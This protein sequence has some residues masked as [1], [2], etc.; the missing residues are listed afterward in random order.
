[1][2]AP[3]ARRHR[4]LS[5]RGRLVAVLLCCL[6]ASCAVVATATTLALRRFLLDR[7]DQQLVT[8]GD[9]YAVSL[10]HPSDAD[11]DDGYFRSV[12]GQPAGTLGARIVD[13]VVTAYGV[14]GSGAQDAATARQTREALAAL[15]RTEHPRSVHLPGLGDYR[16]RVSLGRDGDLLVTGLPEHTVD[17]TVARL[18]VIEAIVF[19]AVVVASGA[20]TAVWVR[21]ALRP[22]N[23]VARTATEVSQL[24]L[25]S[26]EVRLP[27]PVANPAPGTEV[28]QLAEAFNHMLD[29][30]ETSLSTRQA[31]E[32]RLR[33]FIADASHELRTPVAVIRSHAEFAQR[34]GTQ[35]SDEVERALGRIV[36]ESDR[37][38]MLVEDLLLLARLDSGRPL[39][40]DAVDLTRLTLDAVRDA[41]V[42]GAG[43]RW[44]LDLPEE[45]VIVD[46]DE[47][48]L[49]Q[50]LANLL[51]NA[52]THTPP[53]TT[54]TV[55]LDARA[56]GVSLTV[57]DD[58]PGVPEELQPRIFERFVHGDSAARRESGGAG[59]GLSIVAAI[60]QAHGGTASLQSRPG[61]TRFR[62]DLPARSQP[63]PC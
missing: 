48:T 58:G 54:V 16:V 35:S 40:H 7:L 31:S 3:D 44:V 20:A 38:A 43:H 39:A 15:S 27:E 56:D 6:L 57:S 45:P 52:R 42:A 49:H 4:Q 30:V 12:I 46:G 32:D 62:L 24:P 37:M 61:D 34:V 36:G 53:G 60:V 55:T 9:R 18:L 29:H 26:G 14:V 10:E 41:Q 13:G 11:V 2:T 63:E 23:R 19:G 22:L 5:L 33:R 50:V 59:L 28:G 17:E 25:A 8:A 21:V 1:M 51:A 47:H